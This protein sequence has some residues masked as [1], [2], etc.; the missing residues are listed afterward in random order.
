[1][2]QISQAATREILRLS[3]RHQPH[4]SLFFRLGVESKGCCAL[5]YTLNFES[6]IQPDDQL[7]STESIQ[8][9]I[10]TE[11]LKYL[12]GLILDYS[13]DLMGGG[14]RFHNPNAVQ[15]CSCGHSFNVAST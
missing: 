15:A 4:T 5:S 1:M 8:V 7:Y 2:I 13:E 14:F 12:Q 9:V 3:S 6:S 11:Q 10:N